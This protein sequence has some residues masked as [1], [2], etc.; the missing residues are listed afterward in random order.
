M[1]E[2]IFRVKIIKTGES[3]VPGPEVYRMTGWNSWELLHFHMVLAYNG[4]TNFLINTGLPEDLTE[5][6]NAMVQFAGERAK[7]ISLDSIDILKKMG[8]PLG[9]IE[10]ISFTPLQDYTTGR[11]DMFPQ[12]TYHILKKGWIDDIVVP[13]EH[14]KERNLFVPERILRY[15]EFAAR[16]RI[17]YF[18]A[19]LITELVPG[20][21][22]LWVG[23]H[24]RAS[25]AFVIN[26][27]AGKV[28]FT[29]A[30]FK[31]GNITNKIPMGIAENIF[32]CYRAYRF[33]EHYGRILPAYDPEITGMEF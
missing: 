25:L 15:F 9:S 20:I 3:W 18:D 19:E 4:D 28:I 2:N 29:D 27:S 12:A 24:H 14:N 26:T 6:N 32:E 10:N 1:A 16:S 7:F 21:G 33:M 17:K 22:A 13:G 23:C 30:A 11:A 5:R 31:V 8:F